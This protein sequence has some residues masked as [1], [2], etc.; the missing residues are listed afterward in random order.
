MGSQERIIEMN[1]LNKLSLIAVAAVLAAAASAA[2][3]TRQFS[4]KSTDLED[5]DYSAAKSVD[6]KAAT[7]VTVNAYLYIYGSMGAEWVVDGWG[8]GVDA[9]TE[10]IKFFHNETLTLDFEDFDNPGK[11]S[12]TNT[13]AQAVDLEARLEFLNDATNKALFDSSFVEARK[14]NSMFNP[15]GP[16]FEVSGTGGVL[17]LQFTRR[18]TVSPEVGPGVYENVGTIKIIRN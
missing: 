16:N 7:K 8:A 11:V 10:S 6:L 9:Q 3:Q 5:K 4:Y 1:L 2:P 15:S 14:L 12:G 13:G 18:I 17:R